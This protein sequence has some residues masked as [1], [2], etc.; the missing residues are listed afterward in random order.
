MESAGLSCQ[1]HCSM[2]DGSGCRCFSAKVFSWRKTARIWF[3]RA[4][5]CTNLPLSVILCFVYCSVLQ[6]R[7]VHCFSNLCGFLLARGANSLGLSIAEFPQGV[8]INGYPKTDGLW[9]KIPL[10][11]MIWGYPYFRKPPPRGPRSCAKIVTDPSRGSECGSLAH[12]AGGR[13]GLT[14][15]KPTSSKRAHVHVN[16]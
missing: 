9:W 11:W 8:S 12:K 4:T 7:V 6:V 15:G 3:C 13:R 10:K 2:L 1:H 5:I 16:V 14:A